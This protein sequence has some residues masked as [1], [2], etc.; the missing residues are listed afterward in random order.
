MATLSS[1]KIKILPPNVNV[2]IEGRTIVL[3]PITENEVNERYLS[4]LNDSELNQFLEIRYRRQTITDIY[5]YINGLRL[6][7]G[8]EIF[9][10][11][12]KKSNVHVGN[13]AITHYN[14]NNQ[15]TAIYGVMIGEPRALMMGSG[16]EVEALIVEF[17]FRNPEIRKVKAG[18]HAENHKSWRLLESLGF[19]REAILRQEA[20]LRSSKIC[21]T[22]L[23]GILREEWMEQRVKLSFLLRHI[24]IIDK[25]KKTDAVKN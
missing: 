2:V 8:C 25:R 4:W 18:A 5:D 22:Y 15:G 16:A 9:A 13:I 19:K 17:I 14:Q 21:D 11:F 24:K 10:I 23:Y 20:V 12:F 6:S 1:N 7:E 3:M